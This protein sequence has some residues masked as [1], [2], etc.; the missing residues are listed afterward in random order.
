MRTVQPAGAVR[1]AP[2]SSRNLPFCLAAER[3]CRA[4]SW[5]PPLE[6]GRTRYG[7][8]CDR[9]RSAGRTT[10]G[11][12]GRRAVCAAGTGRGLGSGCG[13]VAA[14]ASICARLRLQRGGATPLPDLRAD[15][16]MCLACGGVSGAV[17]GCLRGFGA[18]LPLPRTRRPG[19][20]DIHQHPQ[21]F[22]KL[23]CE[24]A[25]M[26]QANGALATANVR[27]LNTIEASGRP[28]DLR[29]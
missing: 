11:P 24:S 7:L 17:Y 9:K 14:A 12:R 16:D 4:C 13:Y 8:R 21:V 2:R 19:F 5:A 28:R 25:G 6:C 27:P 10:A 1:T 26:G 22:H 15:G 20:H 29:R 23:G 18:A 3:F